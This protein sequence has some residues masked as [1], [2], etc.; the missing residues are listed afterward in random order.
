LW[1]IDITLQIYP[2]REKINLSLHHF[3]LIIG[4]KK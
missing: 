2:I 1:K 4:V 3:V